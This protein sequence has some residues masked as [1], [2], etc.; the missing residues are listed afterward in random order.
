MQLVELACLLLNVTLPGRTALPL[1]G[2][3]QVR[4]GVAGLVVVGGFLVDEFLLG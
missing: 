2:S 1:P 3:G 4:F